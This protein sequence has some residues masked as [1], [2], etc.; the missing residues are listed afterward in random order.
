MHPA[1]ITPA[2]LPSASKCPLRRVVTPVC[3]ADG[4]SSR[5]RRQLLS[6][7]T[8]A[9]F[10][11]LSFPSEAAS[12][13]VTRSREWDRLFDA[14]SGSF[15]P[16]SCIAALMRRD[17]GKAFNRCIVAGETHD[18]ICTHAAQ[19]AVIDSARGLPDAMPLTVGFEQF[20]RMHDAYLRDYVQGKLSINGLLKK[21]RWDETWGFDARL[22]VPIFEYC[23]VHRIPMIGLNLPIQFVRQVSHNGFD[24]LPEALK[25]FLPDNIDV[26]NEGHYRHFMRLMG[27]DDVHFDVKQINNAALGRVYQAQVLWEEWMSQS[28]AMSLKERPGTRMV[29]LIGSGHV[30]GRFGFPDRIEKRC[31]ERPYTIVPRPVSWTSD[32]GHAMPDIL[33]PER[34]VADL[35]WY[36][37]RI[38]DLV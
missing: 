33:S 24:G 38:I 5:T 12:A 15:V 31:D 8:L 13:S 37:R 22:Y 35:I 26:G 32:E 28:V 36:T 9:P 4:P 25:E 21:T 19:L 1:F 30:E 17:V 11:L 27:A 7:L 6:S 29:A 20:Y 34:D 2:I 23:R 18:N 14:R 16:A 10:S 3:N